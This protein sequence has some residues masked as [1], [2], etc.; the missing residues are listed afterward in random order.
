MI[1]KSSERSA[2]GNNMTIMQGTIFGKLYGSVLE[3]KK[4]NNNNNNK[5]DGWN[6]KESKQE[7]N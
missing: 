2:S 6:W 1:F 3:K 4:N 5:I 7:D